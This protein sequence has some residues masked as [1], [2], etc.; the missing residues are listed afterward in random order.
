ME[1]KAFKKTVIICY[2]LNQADESEVSSKGKGRKIG[3]V[4]ASL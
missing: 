2:C 4:C 1:D 3:R